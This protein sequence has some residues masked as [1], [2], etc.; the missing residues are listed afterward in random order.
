M[1]HGEI[2]EIHARSAQVFLGYW[3]DLAATEA[4]LDDDRWYATGDFGRIDDGYLYLESRLRDLIIR[5]GENIYPIEI[6]N[7]LAEHPAV[8]DVAVVGVDH[9][10]LGQ[11]VKAVVVRRTGS[12]VDGDDLRAW[13][14]ETLA[15]HKVPA[16]VVFVA[17]LPRNA[18]GKV[19]KDQ[20][21]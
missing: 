4:V 1:P 17:E 2:G 7:R 5:G 10:T 18:T 8:A 11:E 19:L 12:H 20:L 14:A 3:H 13:A 21:S 9:A 6:E 16:H 15:P